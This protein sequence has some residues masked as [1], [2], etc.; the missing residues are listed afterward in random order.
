MY[1]G[2]LLSILLAATFAVAIPLRAEWN[3]QPRGDAEIA[4]AKLVVDATTL[5]HEKILKMEA[6]LNNPDTAE[7]KR[8]ITTAFGPRVNIAEVKAVVKKLKES[9]IP[10]G[11]ANPKY[12][13]DQYGGKPQ[14]AQVPPNMV[15]GKEDPVPNR[16]GNIMKEV[17][18]GSDFYKKL[19]DDKAGVLIHEATHYLAH[20]NDDV[21]LNV[22]PDG[23]KYSILKLGEVPGNEKYAPRGGYALKDGGKDNA[24]HAD[25]I[26]NKGGSLSAEKYGEYRYYSPNFHQNADSYRVFATLC[27]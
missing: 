11:S 13:D 4:N 5:A 27:S 7:N 10:I 12:L 25:I 14:L 16:E 23:T 24:W 19:R 9:K 15:P 17:Q 2:S 26:A 1:T 22:N 8:K 21:N 20:T 3:S 18:L 6:V